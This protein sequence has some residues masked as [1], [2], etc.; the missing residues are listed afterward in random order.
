MN[1]EQR[2]RRCA[3]CARLRKTLRMLLSAQDDLPISEPSYSHAKV[4]KYVRRTLKKTRN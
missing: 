1:G 2:D 3:N 4:L